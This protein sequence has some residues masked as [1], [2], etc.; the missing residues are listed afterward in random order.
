MAAFSNALIH[1]RAREG[2]E[3]G[4]RSEEESQTEQLYRAPSR[5]R[6]ATRSLF[7]GQQ[8]G[9]LSPTGF[10][11]GSG[12]SRQ[13]K[14]LLPLKCPWARRR[15]PLPASRMGPAQPSGSDIGGSL[16]KRVRG[17]LAS[18]A[19]SDNDGGRAFVC[20]ARALSGV[21]SNASVP[22]WL[23]LRRPPSANHTNATAMAS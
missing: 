1:Q 13:S 9:M 19:V 22:R 23:R 10:F 2:E 5:R 6:A 17:G 14:H 8:G 16:L 11:L 18:P 15:D 3:K 20:R 21:Q 12:P 7:T 4:R